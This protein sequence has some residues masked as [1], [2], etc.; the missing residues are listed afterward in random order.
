M[1]MFELNKISTLI[2]KGTTPTSIGTGFTDSGVKFL[3]AQNIINGSLLLN[4][5]ILHISQR[6]HDTLLK[7]SNI[8]KGDLLITI[9]GTIGRTAIVEGVDEELN[10]NQAVAIIRLK[11]EFVDAKYLKYFIESKNAQDQIT[12]GKVVATIP[13][14]SLSQIS[15][16]KIP[17]PPLSE[18]KRIADLL[19]TADRL[20]QKDKAL[21]EKYDQLA[22]S[23]FLEMFGDPVKNDK[24][25]EVKKLG[26][27]L[28]VQGGY[29]FKSSDYLNNGIRLVKIA[30]VNFEKLI[31]DE[32][33][34]LPTDFLTKYSDFKLNIGDVL[35]ALTRPIIKSLGTI[36][37]VKVTNN[38]VPALLNQR[39]ARFQNNSSYIN[40]YFLIQLIFT[41]E[42]KYLIEKFS[43]TSLQ[44]NVSN[45]QIESIEIGLPPLS[46]QNQFAEQVRLI[47]KQKELAKENLKKSEELF[48]RLMGEVF[49]G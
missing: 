13:N 15:N 43:S 27:I 24:G 25:W 12:N 18:Q 1:N 42:F 14:L 7:R 8:K 22:Q 44:P 34:Y 16:L 45:K 11:E 32:I 20:R 21:L 2:T 31:W 33:D 28:K 17:L 35:M 41:N 9:A 6:D 40:S 48:Q 39:V 46:L 4:D 30:N 49:G 38:D 29:S 26:E 23:L 10:C 37:A 36:K 3:R 47:E 5:D 19:D